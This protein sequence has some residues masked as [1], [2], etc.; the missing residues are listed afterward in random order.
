MIQ[1]HFNPATLSD[2]NN[3]EQISKSKTKVRQWVK[4]IDPGI[5]SKIGIALF[6]FRKIDSFY[7]RCVVSITNRNKII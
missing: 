1:Y 4:M 7:L 5:D 3:L 6:A 2:E